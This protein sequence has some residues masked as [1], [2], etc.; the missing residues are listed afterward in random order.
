MRNLIIATFLC[1][2]ATGVNASV[3]TYNSHNVAKGNK[4]PFHVVI[5]DWYGVIPNGQFGE[6][7]FNDRDPETATY[8]VTLDNGWEVNLNLLATP[9]SELHPYIQSKF[10][11]PDN[12]SSSFSN[13]ENRTSR[14]IH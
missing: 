8:K 11:C 6:F 14:P 10:R 1:L 3:V 7:I 5:D 2:L 4:D 12:H 9:S 13:H